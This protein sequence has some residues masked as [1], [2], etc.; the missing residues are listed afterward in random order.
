MRL[1]S[2]FPMEIPELKPNAEIGEKFY[3]SSVEELKRL[4]NGTVPEALLADVTPP[5]Y[6]KLQSQVAKSD[7]LSHLIAP[8]NKKSR[9][10]ARN[11][12]PSCPVSWVVNFDAYRWPARISKAVCNGQGTTC[13]SSDGRPSCQELLMDFQTYRFLGLTA[14]G[15]QVW[16]S[17]IIAV[18]VSCSCNS[19]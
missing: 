11:V 7:I 3:L 17:E 1:A 18:P 4:G 2:S 12:A 10:S 14:S 5:E 8:S 6:Y 13:L 16:R 9:R 19:S 15:V